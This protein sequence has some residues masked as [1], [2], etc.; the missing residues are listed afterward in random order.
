MKVLLQRV[1]AIPIAKFTRRHLQSMKHFYTFTVITVIAMIASAC[2]A[3]PAPTVNPADIAGTAQAAAFTMI[4]QTQAAIPT[5]TPLPPSATPTLTPLPTDTPMAL[6]TVAILASPTVAPASN[7]AGG[8]PC[9]NRVLGKPKGHSTIIR[10]W[11]ST[12][13][14]INV[15]LYLNETKD[16]GECGYR[17]YS[18]AKNGD[19]IITDLVYGCYN[20]WAWSGDGAKKKFN[21]AGEGCINNSDKW[22]FIVSTAVIKLSPP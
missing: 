15:S 2:G 16:H 3:A 10:I 4:A 18:L 6:P 19:V 9:A 20:L 13:G 14:P 8:D 12:S 17:Q 21:S 5:A 22:T 7:N 11:N 1:A